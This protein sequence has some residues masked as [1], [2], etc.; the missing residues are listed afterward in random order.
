MGFNIAYNLYICITK[1][2]LYNQQAGDRYNKSDT[3]SL[4][5]I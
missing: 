3:Y 2:Y 4:N 1:A 5:Q